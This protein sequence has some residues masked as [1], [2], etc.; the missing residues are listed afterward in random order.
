VFQELKKGKGVI[1][2]EADEIRSGKVDVTQK[3]DDVDGMTAVRVKK[4]G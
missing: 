1:G 3:A 4:I 2:V